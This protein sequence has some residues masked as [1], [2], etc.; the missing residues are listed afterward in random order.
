M[1]GSNELQRTVTVRSGCCCC[2]CCGWWHQD[3]E[4]TYN[5]NN[6]RNATETSLGQSV[7]AW[8]AVAVG[9]CM[10]F[11]VALLFSCWGC[12]FVRSVPGDMIVVAVVVYFFSMDIN[13]VV[14]AAVVL[15]ELLFDWGERH[16]G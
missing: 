15:V 13:D 14:A 12:C 4:L 5:H 3:R 7:C 2:C 11:A 9:V 10:Y 8:V 16:V 1:V 6:I